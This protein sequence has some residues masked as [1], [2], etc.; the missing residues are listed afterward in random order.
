[1]DG[2]TIGLLIGVIGGVVLG[3]IGCLIGAY[4][5]IKRTNGPRERALA[6]RV[7]VAGWVG[8]SVFLACLFLLPM[9]W[10][11][12]LWGVY[13]PALCWFVRWVNE[14]QAFAQV[15]DRGQPGVE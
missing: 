8:V 3:V 14:R 10:R 13:L 9:P 7:A 12:L 2:P 15:E 4:F 5:G 6:N 11:L 1:M